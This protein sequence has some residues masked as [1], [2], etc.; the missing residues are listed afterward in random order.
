MEHIGASKARTRVLC[1]GKRVRRRAE[2][3]SLL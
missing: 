2:F 1:D 3:H